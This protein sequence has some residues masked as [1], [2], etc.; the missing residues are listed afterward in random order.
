[1]NVSEKYARW[2]LSKSGNFNFWLDISFTV[3]LFLTI[4]PG[5]FSESVVPA[6]FGLFLAVAVPYLDSA[7]L[8]LRYNLSKDTRI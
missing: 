7:Y 3:V 8:S 4:L 6:L 1:M 2:R 5:F